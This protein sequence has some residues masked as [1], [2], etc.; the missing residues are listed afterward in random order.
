MTGPARLPV[1][2]TA[3]AGLVAIA[4][5]SS[6]VPAASAQRRECFGRPATIVATRYAGT[7]RGTRHRDVILDLGGA[8]KIHA[9]G[10]DDLVCGSDRSGTIRGGSGDDKIDARAEA[11]YY[12]DAGDDLL[13]ALEERGASH[14]GYF[15]GPGDDR[16]VG[17]G[18]N[19]R[20]VGGPGD[21]LLDS[22]HGY[23]WAVFSGRH[24]VRVDLT[25]GRAA[26]QGHD[27]LIDIDYVEGSARADVITTDDDSYDDVLGLEGDD[28]ISTGDELDR[29][30]AGPGDDVV[31]SGEGLDI[32][33][34]GTGNDYVHAGSGRDR[35]SGGPGDDRIEAGAGADEL[36]EQSHGK[37]GPL[38]NDSMDGGSGHDLVWFLPDFGAGEQ[39]TDAYVDLESG[40]ATF[41]G[42]HTVRDFEDV[43]MATP[44]GAEVYGDDGPNTL[45]VDGSDPVTVSGRGGNDLIGGGLDDDVLDGGR[46]RDTIE[47]QGDG[48]T[49]DLAAGTGLGDD[50]DHDRLTSFENIFG[51]CSG[52]TGDDVLLGDDGPNHIYGDCGN[53]RIEG[54]GGD[55]VLE[56]SWGDDSLD[57]G[58]GTDSLDGGDGADDCVNGETVR[59]C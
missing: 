14:A 6:A 53:D 50:G 11:D 54:R 28:V 33:E 56:G 46:G 10:G 18:G 55:D 5:V 20:F 47:Y 37:R 12:G 30:S 51:S 19:G 8:D 48:V 41:Q 57:G 45:V 25:A 2:K 3:L 38:G 17:R 43:I 40:Q 15:G 22:R 44:G 36:R 23:H 34:T 21:D 49:I 29:I 35:I 52:A 7:V 26:G 9:G 31:R 24:G 59:R 13:L 1:V 16:L 32:V 58:D 42:E 39:V 27:R 4:L